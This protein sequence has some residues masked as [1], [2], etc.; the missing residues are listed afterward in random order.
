MVKEA[1]K[2]NQ[3]QVQPYGN[4]GQ[5]IGKEGNQEKG[6]EKRVTW[7]YPEKEPEFTAEDPK[8]SEMPK[9]LIGDGLR[10]LLQRKDENEVL[11][12]EAGQGAD[13]QVV[14]PSCLK[15]NTLHHYDGAVMMTHQ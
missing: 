1:E 2:S 10:A 7:L 5:V 11:Y 9:G 13:D 8:E 4:Q 14:V 6:K 12:Q 15:D 3:A